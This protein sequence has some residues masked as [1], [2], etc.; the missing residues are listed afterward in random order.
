[1]NRKGTNCIT[2]FHIYFFQGLVDLINGSICKEKHTGIL[3]VGC[4]SGAIS[5]SLAFENQNVHCTAID[6][7]QEACELSEQNCSRFV[8]SCS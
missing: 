3:E 5:L 8:S 2:N 1:M 6:V 7:S 4:G